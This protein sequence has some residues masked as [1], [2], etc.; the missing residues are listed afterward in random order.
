M[1]VAVGEYLFQ[2]VPSIYSFA[3][4]DTTQSFLQ[5]Q[6]HILA[7]LIIQV[8]AVFM[9][10]VLINYMGAAWSKNIT[11]FF[12]S[13]AIYIY[14]ISLS[15]PLKSWIEWTIKCIKGWGNHMKFL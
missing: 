6:G 15:K 7:P 9:H 3:F 10:L 5:T 11:D 13:V 2:L 14:I 4:Y 8:V 1:S 12:S